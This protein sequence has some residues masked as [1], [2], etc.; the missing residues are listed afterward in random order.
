MIDKVKRLILNADDLEPRPKL[1][2]QLNLPIALESYGQQA[3]W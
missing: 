3:S 2:K 1:T